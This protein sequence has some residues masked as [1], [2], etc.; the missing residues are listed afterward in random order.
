VGTPKRKGREMRV[1]II[2]ELIMNTIS[3]LE[4][5]ENS[6]KELDRKARCSKEVLINKISE[7]PTGVEKRW[8]ITN[9]INLSALKSLYICHFVVYKIKEDPS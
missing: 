2:K 7:E 6:P 8:L 3:F 4:R 5:E 1:S 9:A